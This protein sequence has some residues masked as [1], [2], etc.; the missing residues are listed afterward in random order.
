LPN[1]RPWGFTYRPKGDPTD[2]SNSWSVMA[3]RVGIIQY[4]DVPADGVIDEGALVP[5]DGSTII[6]PP[7]GGCGMPR[8]DCFRGYFVQRLFPRDAAGTVFGYIVE[9]DSWEELESADEEQI[10]RLAQKA[11]Q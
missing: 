10:A 6:S 1:L 9:F 11:M 4:D 8:C 5:V 3:I 2:A 7:D